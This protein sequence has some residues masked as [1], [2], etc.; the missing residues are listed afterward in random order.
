[1]VKR[2]RS[3][4]AGRIAWALVDQALSSGTNFAVTLLI[5]RSVTIV[6]FGIYSIAFASYLLLLGTSRALVIHPYMVRIASLGESDATEAARQSVIGGSLLIGFAG[7]LVFSA[8]S[9]LFTG[10][11]SQTLLVFSATIPG[12]LLQDAWRF[13]FF[14]DGKPS[15]AA[16]N[17]FVWAVCQLGLI[18][19][20]LAVAGPSVPLLILAWG[21]SGSAGAAFGFLQ[22]KTRPDLRRAVR[23]VRGHRDL[24]L[25]F[26]GQFGLTHGNDQV[27]M[28]GITA[29]AG[30]ATIGT[31]Q[32]AEVLVRPLNFL[33]LGISVAAF[34]EGVRLRNRSMRALTTGMITISAVLV[35]AAV[36]LGVLLLV[37]PASVGRLLLGNNWEVAQPIIF[38][39]LLHRLLFGATEGPRMGVQILGAASRGLR[40]QLVLA[41]INLAANVAGAA[42]AGAQGAVMG[43]VGALLLATGLWWWQYLSAVGRYRPGD[44]FGASLSRGVGPTPSLE[45]LPQS[46]AGPPVEAR[47]LRR[48]EQPRK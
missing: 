5:A 46:G 37:M 48:H 18:L 22:Q 6:D 20:T 28:Y 29:V 32:A 35:L 25:P 47:P 13:V 41:P 34:P 1:V 23:W 43:G 4:V 31:I 7:A 39:L 38:W 12:L 19:G 9:F 33:T 14:G 11:L 8:A 36:L 45:E 26:L 10:M 3:R 27:Q 40:T 17:D 24:G 42:I 44:E 2:G 15:H 21:A 30:L 16:L